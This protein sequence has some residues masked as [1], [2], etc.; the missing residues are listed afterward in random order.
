MRTL[1]TGILATFGLAAFAASGLAQQTL[2]THSGFARGSNF[3]YAVAGV[4]D[5][6]LDGTE[7]FIVGM[8]DYDSGAVNRG[9]VRIVSGATGSTIRSISGTNAGDRFGYSVAFVGDT[10]SDGVPEFVVGAPY[11]APNGTSSGQARMINGATGATLLTLNGNAAGNRFGHAVATGGTPFLGDRRFIVG[12]PFEDNGGSSRGSAYLYT[13]TGTLLKE[14]TGTQDG[15]NFGWSVAG[16]RECSGDLTP[17]LV[18]G[19]PGYDDNGS[20]TGRARLFN[21]SSYSTLE[22]VPGAGP[23]HEF[24]YS[25]ALIGDLN[26]DSLSDF[27]V[28]APGFVSDQGAVYVHS[29]SNGAI[30]STKLG[31]A[32]GDR[33]GTAVVNALDMNSDGTHDYLVG[34]PDATTGGAVGTITLYSGATGNVLRLF[35]GPNTIGSDSGFGTAIG[36]ADINNNGRNDVIAGAE[37]A[38]VS[39]VLDVGRV[40]AYNGNGYAQL[41]SIDGAT[42]GSQLGTSTTG[43]GD[44]NGDGKSDYVVGCPDFD[45]QNVIIPNG[46]YDDRA[47]FARC[48]S[49]ANGAILWTNYG[50]E[51]DNLGFSVARIKDVNGDGRDDVAIGAP[52]D[53]KGTAGLG[54]VRVVSGATGS[55]LFTISGSGLDDEFGY[56]VADAGDINGNGTTDIIIG[57]PGYDSDRGRAVF[58][59]GNTG[60]IL[61]SLNGQVAGE[62]FGEAVSSLGDITGDG[63]SDLLIGAPS[64]DTVATNAGRVYGVNQTGNVI[65]F[66]LSGTNAS[67]RFGASVAGL[68]DYTSDGR[69]EFVVGCPG[70]DYPGLTN[71][72]FVRTYFSSPV[73]EYWTYYGSAAEEALG[74]RVVNLGDTSGDGWADIA[75]TGGELSLLGSGAGVVRIFGGYGGFEYY[76]LDGAASADF[77]G[78]GLGAAGDI[79]GD[80]IPDIVIGS[81]FSDGSAEATGSARAISLAPIGISR[82]GASTPGCQGP[83]VLKAASAARPGRYLLM[84]SDKTEPYVLGATLVTDAKNPA[85]GDVFGIGVS[86]YLDFVNATEFFSLDAY[87]LYNGHNF[88]AAV[89][90]VD[91][92]LTGKHYYAQTINYFTT[93]SLPPLNLSATDAIDIEIQP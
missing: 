93:C 26:G 20:N 76:Q 19:S 65:L 22:T 41:L 54:Y 43:I 21:G 33:F 69:N 35:N 71:C 9:Q 91:S 14:F 7:D 89:V 11:A 66:T 64:N 72:G 61:N 58:V 68:S 88:S 17:D 52:Q 36:V 90:P 6:N 2:H 84:A 50:A 63:R 29:S 75:A 60:A 79:D 80:T 62:R 3:G 32:I 51:G 8:P 12:A 16:G 15:E 87:G 82:F 24:G 37:N 78:G 38:T 86:L 34:A 57:A 85:G 23:G 74:T 45:R 42:Y 56:A 18:V 10:N 70:G 13:E 92:M 59:S 1:T 28:G 49:G 48:Y 27:I 81:P 83:H 4:G 53:D 73:L 46:F 77:F 25:V 30:L 39:S 40:Y 67:D 55:T 31:A 5:I 47:G 44:V